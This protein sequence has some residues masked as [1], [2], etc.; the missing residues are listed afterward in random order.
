MTPQQ[1]PKGEQQANGV[2]EEAGRTVRDHARVLKID[3]QAKVG[4]NIEP[5]EPIRP[6]LIRWAAMALSRYSRGK[7]G[8]TPYQIQ[9]GRSCDIE[10]V[11]FGEPCGLFE[12][13]QLCAFSLKK[14]KLGNIRRRVSFF[15]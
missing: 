4:R 1:P 15:I 7:A 14:Y 6:W 12:K 8:K 11:Q 3:L 10:V 13:I 2:A 5:D 9:V